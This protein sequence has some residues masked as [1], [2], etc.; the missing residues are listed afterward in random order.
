MNMT[1]PTNGTTPNPTPARTGETGERRRPLIE[2]VVVMVLPVRI[3]PS[4]LARL[5]PVVIHVVMVLPAHRL[6]MLTSVAV[7]AVDQTNNVVEVDPVQRSLTV[8][9]S[10]TRRVQ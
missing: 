7:S 3:V 6:P 4:A 5:V 10:Q 1:E 8:W 9:L 2:T